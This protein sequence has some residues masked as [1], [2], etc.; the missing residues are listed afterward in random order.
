LD[1]LLYKNQIRDFEAKVKYL[2]DISQGMK[3]LHERGIMHR[4]LKPQNILVNK[5]NICKLCDFG[6]AK[7]INETLTLGVIGTW[8]YMAPEI[9]NETEAYNEKCDVYSFGIMMHEI[10]T[11]SKPYVTLS[12]E[13]VNQF[14]MGLKIINGQ[15]PII[16][17]ELFSNEES[18]HMLLNILDWFFKTN[19]LSSS[20]AIANSDLFNIIKMYF[21]LCMACWTIRSSERPTFD[22]I[23]TNL[24]EILNLLQCKHTENICA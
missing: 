21:K 15:R 7:V 9:M 11:L 24:Q 20:L 5:D 12:E 8:Q 22:I 4:D 16:P 18:E 6:L 3:F 19:E 17:S 14:T 2:L 23:I 13:Y 10:F 1:S